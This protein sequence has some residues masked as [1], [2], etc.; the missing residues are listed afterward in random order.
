M[1]RRALII[2]GGFAGCCAAHMLHQI[3]WHATIV[4]RGPE[5]GAGVRTKWYGGHP[6]TFGPRH[7]LT[8]DDKV[9][10]YMDDIVKLRDC[11]D[12]EFWT[13]VEGDEAFYNFPIHVDDIDRMPDEEKIRTELLDQKRWETPM[14]SIH[15]FEEFWIASVGETLYRKMIDGYSRKM[16]R[17]ADNKSLDTFNWSPKGVAIKEGPRAAWDSAMSAYPFAADGYNRY[18]DVATA[19]ATVHLNTEIQAIDMAAKRVWMDGGKSEIFDL[20][21][22]TASPDDI[23]GGEF[24]ALRYIG[25]D[26]HKLVLPI[27]RVFPP[28]VYFLYYAGSEEFTRL[29]E[30]KA[31]TH[32]ESPTT[33]IGIEVPSMNGRHYPMPTK[34]EQAKAALYHAAMP[35]GV[36]SIGR[37]G[38][39]RY[40]LDIAGCIEQVFSM[41][42][43]IK[44]GGQEHAVPGSRW[45]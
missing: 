12:H 23:M 24:G 39:Y 30:Y 21:V 25:R 4:E 31:F 44:Q 35:K 9:Y 15:N 34:S 41:I 13:Y 45:R 26:F 29:V 5:L 14:N 1:R 40:G 27:E 19:E 43:E 2:G 32:H 33:L 22:N 18:F 28:H 37:L 8:K 17:I 20:I 36:Y 16:W 6:Y 3:G 7:F 42:E 10:A 11:G 38:S